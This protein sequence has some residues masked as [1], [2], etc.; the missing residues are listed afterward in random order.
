MNHLAQAGI[1]VLEELRDTEEEGGGFVGGKLLP[2]VEEE[3]YLGEED[4]ASSRLDRRTVEQSGYTSR[5]ALVLDE[6][7]FSRV[8]W[9]SRAMLR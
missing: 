9:S 7:G 3:S 8:G 2:R 1:L 4:T 5:L 6:F